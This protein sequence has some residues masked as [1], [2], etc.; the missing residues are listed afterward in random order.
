VTRVTSPVFWARHTT[1]YDGELILLFV[2]GAITAAAGWG[3]A[4]LTAKIQGRPEEL[5]F[6]VLFSPP[7]GRHNGKGRSVAQA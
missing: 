6:G 7:G 1:S 2:V 4:Y 5:K 3:V